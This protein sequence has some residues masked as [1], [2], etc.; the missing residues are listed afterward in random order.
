MYNIQSLNNHNE[1]RS[2]INIHTNHLDKKFL[3]KKIIGFYFNE[4]KK[5]IKRYINNNISSGNN[6]SDNFGIN[7]TNNIYGNKIFSPNTSNF[8]K[9]KSS[10]KLL[11]NFTKREK[12][13]NFKGKM[14]KFKLSGNN[15]NNM[16][17]CNYLS[18]AIGFHFNT[19][20][21]NNERTYSTS[22]LKNIG[23]KTFKYDK[24]K[25]INNYKNNTGRKYRS[26]SNNKNRIPLNNVI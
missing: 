16:L 4:G 3:E 14:T 17:Y 8:P 18:N 20:K 10:T 6:N 9:T 19:N 23:N 26:C 11:T 24:A 15:G 13:F 5:V 7:K 22:D 25:Y 12:N 1:N 21:K 2:S